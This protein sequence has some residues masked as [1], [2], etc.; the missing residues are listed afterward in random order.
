MAP[1]AQM[2]NSQMPE[3]QASGFKITKILLKR[4]LLTGLIVGSVI[5][6]IHNIDVIF[7]VEFPKIWK[8]LLTYCVP[9]CVTIWGAYIATK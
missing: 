9:F 7:M 1:D 2:P 3:A 5:N 4:A 8:M 6:A